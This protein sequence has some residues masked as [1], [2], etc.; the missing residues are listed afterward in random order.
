MV[1]INVPFKCRPRQH[2]EGFHK[3]WL[4]G[5]L[6]MEVGSIPSLVYRGLFERPARPG[7]PASAH[8]AYNDIIH[9]TNNE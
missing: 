3:Q 4:D 5:L 2:A 6:D 1:P 7:V 8:N 9:Y